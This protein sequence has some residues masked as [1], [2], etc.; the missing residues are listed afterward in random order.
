MKQAKIADILSAE[1]LTEMC[2]KYSA[3]MIQSTKVEDL[4]VKTLR[5]LWF[6]MAPARLENMQTS[7]MNIISEAYQWISIEAKK[8]ELVIFNPYPN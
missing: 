8:K 1:E 3:E 6:I 4:T 5:N 2:K 7:G